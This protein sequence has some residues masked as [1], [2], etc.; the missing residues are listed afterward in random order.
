VPQFSALSEWHS[1]TLDSPG[2]LLVTLLRGEKPC[3][4]G[5]AV[6]S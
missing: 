6:K 2:S 5:E 1:V 4:F 3:H